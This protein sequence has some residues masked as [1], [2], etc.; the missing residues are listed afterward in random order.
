MSGSLI[1]RSFPLRFT[2]SVPRNKTELLCEATAAARKLWI[3]Y[4]PRGSDGAWSKAE[5]GGGGAEITEVAL[6]AGITPC[7]EYNLQLKA[8]AGRAGEFVRL[9][10]I[11]AGP[12]AVGRLAVASVNGS[13]ALLKWELDGESAKCYE[14][15]TLT[16]K[17]RRNGDET[18]LPDRKS[19]NGRVTDFKGGLKPRFK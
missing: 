10:R 15:L 4:R 11:R 3:R 13:A 14:E 8:A 12:R 1:S 5:V 18:T 7:T 16:Q 6:D 17:W 2:V 9:G 19:V